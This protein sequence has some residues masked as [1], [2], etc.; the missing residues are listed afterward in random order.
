LC[1]GSGA[2]TNSYMAIVDAVAAGSFRVHI[3]NLTAGALG[4]ALVLNYSIIK[5]YF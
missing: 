1:I 3:R 4:E 2:T 5:N